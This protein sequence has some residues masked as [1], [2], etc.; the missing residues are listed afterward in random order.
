MRILVFG[1]TG[2]IGGHAARWLTK[3]GHAVTVVVRQETQADLFRAEG[4]ETLIGDARSLSYTPEFFASFDAVLWAAQLMLEEEEAVCSAMLRALAKTNKAFIFTSGTS[5]LSQP[6]NG[7]WSE[8]SFSEYDDFLPRRQVA[9]RRGIETMVRVAAHYGVR[10]MVVRPPLIWGHGGCRI[11]EDLYHSARKT[12]AVCYVGSGLNLYTHV[13]VDD[14]S[15]LYALAF[16]KGV[17]GALYH[18]AAG[19]VNF[20]TM[21]ESI[22]R[23]MGI[24]T[25]S[26]TIEE[27]AEIWDPFMGPIVFSGCSRCRASRSRLELGWKASLDKRDLLEE[28]IAPNYALATERAPPSWV[29]KT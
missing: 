16:E 15:E 23:H 7:E 5:L 19:E 28:C 17:A 21:A 25:R 13:H 2:Y 14:L 12:G 20:R 3:A 6:T 29:R 24:A 26:V 22:A 11:V 1:A 18:L 27:A 8:E 10:S 9:A 4:M